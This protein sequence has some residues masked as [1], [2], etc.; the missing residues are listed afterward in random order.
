LTVAGDWLDRHTNQ[1]PAALR[2]RVHQYVR[3]VSGP[4]LAH[5]LVTA[6]QTALARV[7]AHPGDRSVALD[8]LAAD[9]LVTLALQHQAQT[10]PERLEE[11]ATSVLQTTRSGA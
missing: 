4:A 11:F 10:A 7:L 5:T 2:A 6:G 3:A 8:L 9:A 1:A